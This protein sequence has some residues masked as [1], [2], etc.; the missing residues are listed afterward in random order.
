[1]GK[2]WIHHRHR[3][4]TLDDVVDVLAAILAVLHAQSGG[5]TDAGISAKLDQILKEEA[6]MAG[7]LQDLQAGVANNSSVIQSAITAIQ[8]IKAAL[9]AAIASGDPA[10]LKALSDQLGTDDA[11]LAA[12]VAANTVAAGQ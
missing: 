8:N 4:A 1:M 7:E 6:Q 3:P 2:P 5:T 12:A 11:A 9:D 10:A